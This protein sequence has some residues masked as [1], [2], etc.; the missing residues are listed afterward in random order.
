M[1]DNSK[2]FHRF[3]SESILFKGRT[4][5]YYC[6]LKAGRIMQVLFFLAA[7]AAAAER[8]D[9]EGLARRA[10]LLP[11]DIAHLASGEVD[12]AVVLADIFALLSGLQM[13]TAGGVLSKENALVI[14]AE[15]E[16]I[17]ERLVRGSHPS[18]FL[19][20]DDFGVPELHEPSASTLSAPGHFG[21]LSSPTAVLKDKQPKGQNK[22]QSDRMSLILELV[23][24][25]KSLSIKEIAAVIKDCSEKTIQREL[26]SLIQQG[27]VRKVGERRWSL[28]LPA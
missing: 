3:A 5:W 9:L 4:D 22:G 21:R 20:S 10:G 15:Y 23:R 6:Y 11:G 2:K 17:A 16:A 28:Y 19:S 25:K 14:E 7:N 27:L 1:P 18:P 8:D 24:K 13:L 12:A 26:G